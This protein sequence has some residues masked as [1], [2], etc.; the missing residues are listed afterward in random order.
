MKKLFILI[1]LFLIKSVTCTDT[2]SDTLYGT[3]NPVARCSGK[4]IDQALRLGEGCAP[5]P[6]LMSLPWPNGTQIDQVIMKIYKY[7]S[8]MIIPYYNIC[9]VNIRHIRHMTKD[10]CIGIPSKCF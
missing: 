6:T 9:S 10:N 1:P 3:Y 5:R 4:H 8:I 2:C 7:H